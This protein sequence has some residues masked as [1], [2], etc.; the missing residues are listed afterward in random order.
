MLFSNYFPLDRD[1]FEVVQ[2]DINSPLTDL[3]D[4]AKLEELENRT[5]VDYKNVFFVSAALL[6]GYISWKFEP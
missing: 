6:A 1:G 2:F 3:K 5:I 4:Q